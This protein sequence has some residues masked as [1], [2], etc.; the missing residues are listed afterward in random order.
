MDNKSKSKEISRIDSV[1][2]IIDGGIG[3]VFNRVVY[4]KST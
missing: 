4:I 2:R 3:V 1:D